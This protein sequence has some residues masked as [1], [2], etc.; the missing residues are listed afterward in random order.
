MP[1][2]ICSPEPDG[3]DLVEKFSK[4]YNIRIAIHNH[5]PGDQ[6]Y[7]S[8]LDVLKL[9]KARDPRMGI[10]MDVGHTVRIWTGPGGSDPQ[11]LRALVRLPHQG[12]DPG[13]RQRKVHRGR[14]RRDRHCSPFSRRCCEVKFSGHLALEYE[15]KG[16][17]PLAGMTESF[18]YIRGVPPAI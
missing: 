15:D 18:G 8:P 9:V 5:G 11:M 2:I 17:A 14:Q 3:L 7:P 12:R 4:Q 13:R 1:T 10:C 6:K 16:E